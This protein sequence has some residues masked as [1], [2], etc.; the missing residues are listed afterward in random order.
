MLDAVRKATDPDEELGDLEKRGISLVKVIRDIDV[1][2]G[3]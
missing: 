1:R 3:D 2:E